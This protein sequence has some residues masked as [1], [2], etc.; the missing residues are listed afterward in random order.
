MVNI[1]PH[2]KYD[3]FEKE[4]R[5]KFLSMN[6]SVE[7]ASCPCRDLPWPQ[8]PDQKE[9]ICHWPNLHKHIREWEEKRT[10][11]GVVMGSLSA[12][13]LKPSLRSAESE[14]RKLSLQGDQEI[15]QSVY[16]RMKNVTDYLYTGLEEVYSCEDKKM[17]GNIR[18]VLDLERLLQLTKEMSPAVV[19]QREVSKF[20]TAAEVIDQDFDVKYEKSEMR[21]QYRNFVE[22]ISEIGEQ[23]NSENLTSIE[24]VVM[25]MNT[26]Q[27]R[28]RGCEAAMDIVCQAATMKTIESV[29]ESWVSVLEHHSSKSRSL[30]AETIQRE[31]MISENG[32]QVQHS[33]TVVEESMKLYWSKLS[34]S[35]LKQRHFTR[36]SRSEKVKSYFVS[37]SV[38]SLNSV[39]I[40]TPLIL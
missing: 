27:K 32:P 30:K 19:V 8:L 37:K 36:R 10:F 24:I 5:E 15:I 11:R 29:V 7:L 2:V 25:M 38:D 13:P 4:C 31:M 6:R 40:K 17:L 1:L 20:I 12:D 28:W 26:E 21:I 3:K 18:T 22:S 23:E 33:Q 35:N 39:P 16:E 14:A 34:T 9:V